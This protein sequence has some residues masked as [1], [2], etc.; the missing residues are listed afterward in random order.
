[1]MDLRRA[2]GR[3][4][5][6]LLTLA[7][8]PASVCSVS[9]RTGLYPARQ[10][11]TVSNSSFFLDSSGKPQF[12]SSVKYWTD[13]VDDNPP[14][15][16]PVPRDALPNMVFDGQKTTPAPWVPFTR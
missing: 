1:M 15:T 16:P 11:P 14:G 6:R 10:G 8:L 7:L 4:L 5:A 2:F 9:R 13:L 3:S 12:S